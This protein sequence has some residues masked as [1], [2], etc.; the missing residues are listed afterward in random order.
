MDCRH[1]ASSQ[2]RYQIQSLLL[3][4]PVAREARSF[5]LG[6][7]ATRKSTLGSCGHSEHLQETLYFLPKCEE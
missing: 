1:G 3:I 2:G 7:Q 5:D 4:W 6:V